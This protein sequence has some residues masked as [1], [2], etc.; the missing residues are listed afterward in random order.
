M[1]RVGL[2]LK[3]GADQAEIVARDV[4]S[5]LVQNGCEAVVVGDVAVPGARRLA[6]E[7]LGDEVDLLLVLGG[8]GTLLHAAGLVGEKNTAILG[9]NLGRLGFLTPFDLSEAKT[10][11]QAA[12][13][14]RLP[15][16]ERMRLLVT[17]KNKTGVEHRIALN[18]AVV[19]QGAVVQLIE[20]VARLDGQR[21][22]N[23][24]ADGL[25]VC[26]PTGSTAYNLAAGGPILPPGQGAMAIT[27]INPHTLTN[28]PLVVSA[29]SVVEIE[30]IDDTHKA[31]LSVDGQ[32]D[33][34][35]SAGDKVEIRKA[36]TPLRL[37]QSQKTYFEILQ[38]KLKWGEREKS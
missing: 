16:E 18:D 11:L 31:L 14:G 29:R 34:P 21:I 27:P 32:W 38:E 1:K 23:Y 36:D 20:L 3:R 26:T 37:I 33:R 30:L 35:L 17:I 24:K 8:D 22:T 25:I 2:V 19:C 15:I 7:D 13:K 10:A 4:A 5:W 28:R 12:L 6:E 9:V